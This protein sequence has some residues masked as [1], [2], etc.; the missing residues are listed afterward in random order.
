M[1][2]A[3]HGRG[4]FDRQSETCRRVLPSMPPTIAHSAN[5][6][7]LRSMRARFPVL[8]AVILVGVIL[9][10]RGERIFE[11]PEIGRR[12]RMTARTDLGLPALLAHGDAAADNFVD[13]R[14][15][16]SDVID[17][18]FAG[19]I[20]HEEIV[21]IAD[22]LAAREYAVPGILVADR[23]TELFGVESP[24]RR[25]IRGEHDDVS[26]IDRMWHARRPASAD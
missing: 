19:T 24:H 1:P 2:H 11:V 13:V 14:H 21:V 17:A 16:E 6:S 5:N 22:P 12:N 20:E 18:G 25:K 10:R 3:T 4:R 26:D 9:E 8:G 7:G 23:E 15:G